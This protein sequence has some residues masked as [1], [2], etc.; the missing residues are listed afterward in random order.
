MNNRAA[1]TH[2]TMKMLLALAAIS[3]VALPAVAV[4]QVVFQGRDGPGKG[5]HIVLLAGDEEYRSEEA[6]PQLAR[7]LSE[8]HG[9]KC[10]VSFSIN[11]ETG[12]IDPNTKDN[13]PGIE[14][15]DT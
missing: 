5:K 8:R 9:F 10:T 14:A 2:Q 15:L 4:A 6:L 12:E 3:L 7:I 11:K 1:S 13:Q